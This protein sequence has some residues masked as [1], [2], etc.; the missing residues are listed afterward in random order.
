MTLPDPGVWTEHRASAG[1]TQ[2]MIP[3]PWVRARSGRPCP[4]RPTFSLEKP[5]TRKRW[6]L[7]GAPREWSVDKAVNGADRMS[8]SKA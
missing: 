2:D 6:E 5:G 4:G 3:K 7:P 8:V 1:V